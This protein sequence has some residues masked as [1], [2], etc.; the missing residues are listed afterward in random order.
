MV[1]KRSASP[2]PCF[3]PVTLSAGPPRPASPM[4]AAPW[5]VWHVPSKMRWPSAAAVALV[6][7]GLVT[8][9]D[10]GGCCAKSAPVAT[11]AMEHA[12]SLIRLFIVS[13]T[14]PPWRTP[15]SMKELGTPRPISVCPIWSPAKRCRGMPPRNEGHAGDVNLPPHCPFVK[16]VQDELPGSPRLCGRALASC[17]QRKR[18]DI[19][20]RRQ[21]HQA[22]LS[23]TRA[24]LHFPYLFDDTEV[25]R[26]T[27]RSALPDSSSTTGGGARLPRTARRQ[28]S[29]TEIPVT[30]KDLRSA[31]DG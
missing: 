29:R 22:C 20:S 8:V 28:P 14:I 1:Q 4:P 7:S 27:T 24:Q 10:T 31:L 19:A 2:S 21:P 9:S 11:A 26:A 5:Q 13:E 23:G 18:R 25:A 30:G 6:A 3:S 16:H 12:T 15:S 17:H